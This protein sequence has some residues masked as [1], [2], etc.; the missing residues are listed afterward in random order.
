[1]PDDLE[2]LTPASI[3]E[4][5]FSLLYALQFDERGKPRGVKVKANEQLTAEWLMRHLLR[6]GYVILR[7]PPLRAH[8]TP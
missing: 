1:M 5:T 3:E 2:P 6:S 7:K 4:V 8:T